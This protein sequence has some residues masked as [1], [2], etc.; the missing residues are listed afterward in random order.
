MVSDTP[1][2]YQY[3]MLSNIKDGMISDELPYLL[4]LDEKQE[5]YC[6]KNNSLVISKNGSPIKV[7]IASVEDGQHIL[8]NGNL[9]VI[10]LDETKANPYFVKAYLESEEGTIALSRITAE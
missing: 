4:G 3:L 10:E 5:K 8:V 6:L 2:S 7:A 9:Y 1:T